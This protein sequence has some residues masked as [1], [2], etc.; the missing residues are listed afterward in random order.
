MFVE[1]CLSDNHEGGGSVVVVVGFI[2]GRRLGVGGSSGEGEGCV[3]VSGDVTEGVIVG[4]VISKGETSGGGV[5]EE[6]GDGFDFA[7][8]FVACDVA[9][10]L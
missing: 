6:S 2:E 5:E 1:G 9:D 8:V 4:V 3:V 10:A 7:G